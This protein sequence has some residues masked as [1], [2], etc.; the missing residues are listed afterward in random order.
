MRHCPKECHLIRPFDI[1]VIICVALICGSIAFFWINA[2]GRRKGKLE[3]SPGT[4]VIYLFDHGVLQHASGATKDLAPLEAGFHEWNDLR[5]KIVDRFSLF[6][7]QPKLVGVGSQTLDAVDMNGPTQVNITW[8]NG[9][10]RVQFLTFEKDEPANA[11]ENRIQSYRLAASLTIPV[12]TTSR[13]GHL[14]WWNPAYGALQA[15]VFPGLSVEDQPIFPAVAPTSAPRVSLRIAENGKK[16]WF[17]ISQT[18]CDDVVIYQ[19]ICISNLVHAEEAQ[20]NFVQ[21]LTKTFAQLSIGLAIFDRNGQLALFNPAL[22][23][24]TGLRAEFLSARPALQTFF[25]RLRETRKMP[26][27]KNYADW[28]TAVSELVTAANDGRYEDIWSLDSGQT[29]RVKGRPHPDGATAFLIEDI[30]AEVSLTR[31][32]RAELELGQSMLDTL[33][34]GIAVFSGSGI[35]TFSNAAYQNL[36]QVDPETSFA[37]V[38][39][40]DAIQDWKRKSAPTP[41]WEEIERFVRSFADRKTWRF[42]VYLTDNTHLTCVIS[43]IVSGATLIRFH[44]VKRLVQTGSAAS[45]IEQDQDA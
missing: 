1:V 4:E 8:E 26:E 27:P 35:L 19:A 5:E 14:L 41:M 30:T 24:L 20:R 17:D 10:S 38:T 36:W 29:F 16:E 23:D 15:R 12:W 31:N 3:Q 34:D 43:P 2:Q 28:R 21:T 7:I 42:P 18:E 39:I 40:H 33:D 45:L 13:E 6:P 25:D 11:V 44:I 22:V 32:F 9:L 37:D